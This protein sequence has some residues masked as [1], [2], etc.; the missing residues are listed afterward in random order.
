M[1]MQPNRRRRVNMINAKPINPRINKAG[2]G[3]N[4]EDIIFFASNILMQSENC[5]VSDKNEDFLFS[6]PMNVPQ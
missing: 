3:I 2:S 5:S 4:S 6:R 1:T